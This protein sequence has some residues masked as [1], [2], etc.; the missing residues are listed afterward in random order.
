MLSELFNAPRRIRAIRS[1][2]A[3]ELIESF[4][5]ELLQRGYSKISIRCH[6]QSAERVVLFG[7]QSYRA[8]L[9]ITCM[10]KLS[11]VSVITCVDA[12]AVVAPARG[13]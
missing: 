6:I 8:Y 12:R 9:L 5:K 7:G 13:R 1:G 2:P 4:A 11:K 10:N 3:G